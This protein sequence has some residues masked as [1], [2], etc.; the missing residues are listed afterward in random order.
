MAVTVEELQIVLGVDATK[1]Q[2]T[3]DAL[4]QKVNAATNRIGDMNIGAAVDTFRWL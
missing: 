2:A 4:N 3:L 1:A